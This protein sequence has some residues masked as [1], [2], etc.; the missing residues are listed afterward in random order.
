MEHALS[1]SMHA[2]SNGLIYTEDQLHNNE[3]PSHE[4]RID[5]APEFPCSLSSVGSIDKEPGRMQET[6]GQE[7][8]PCSPAE[9]I[10]KEP[11]WPQ[12]TW[13]KV[14]CSPAA[15]IDKEPRRAQEV[16]DRVPCS[17]TEGLDKGAGQSQGK[18]GGPCSRSGGTIS[19]DPSRVQEASHIPCSMSAE[20][21]DNETERIRKARQDKVPCAGAVDKI[22]Q[23]RQ[24]SAPYPFLA[25][26]KEIQAGVPTAESRGMRTQEEKQNR[27]PHPFSAVGKNQC[28][29]SPDT[30]DRPRGQALCA[31]VMEER[32]VANGR[33]PMVN[34]NP[35]SSGYLQWWMVDSS[36]VEVYI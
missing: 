25:T 29:L 5:K 6:C 23:D 10:D 12:R 17:T 14:P 16:W 4:L 36:T 11:R 19:N 20:A 35:L 30:M 22:T 7:R 8:A 3:Q 1:L 13:D 26:G 18:N 27:A 32:G 9:V 15:A 24:G 34:Y 2:L 33:P 21:A 28:P 31:G